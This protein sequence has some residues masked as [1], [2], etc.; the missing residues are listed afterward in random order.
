MLVDSETHTSE[1]PL[2]SLVLK[3]LYANKQIILPTIYNHIAIT[4]LIENKLGTKTYLS[5]RM[6]GGKLAHPH[7]PLH[8]M[9]HL[10][11][12]LNVIKDHTTTKFQAWVMVSLEGLEK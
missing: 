12:H 4:S 9:L 7:A 3:T 11:K 8:D 6:K 1:A 2:G 5:R 10:G